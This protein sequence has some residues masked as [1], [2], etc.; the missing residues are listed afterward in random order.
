ME[1]VRSVPERLH[2]IPEYKYYV[3]RAP[4][5][6]SQSSH[7]SAGAS[8]ER[9]CST[10]PIA[11]PF[12]LDY[13]YNMDS[14]DTLPESV[15]TVMDTLASVPIWMWAVGS[16]VGISGILLLV[17]PSSNISFARSIFFHCDACG[18][19]AAADRSSELRSMLAVYFWCQRLEHLA[20]PRSNM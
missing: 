20:R 14:A 17:F 19:W 8:G 2:K 10:L 3:R 9:I 6:P 18:C 5:P 15:W 12:P 11:L 7:V 1:T 13:P 16:I 4:R